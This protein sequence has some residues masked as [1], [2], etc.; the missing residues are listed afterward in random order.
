VPQHEDSQQ[1][2]GELEGGAASSQVTG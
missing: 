1:L 2:E